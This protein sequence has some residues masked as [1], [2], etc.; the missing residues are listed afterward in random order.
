VAPLTLDRGEALKQ[1][2]RVFWEG[3]PCGAM[4]ASAVEGTPEY[5]AQVEESRYLL[6][7]FIPK[8]ADFEGA[9][10][11]QL[12]EIGVGLGTDLVRFARAGA[13]VTG[14]DLTDHAVELV[15]RRLELEGLD[16][17]VEVADAEALPFP[18]ASFDRVYSWGV[19]H[20]TPDTQRAIDEAI[21]VA[22]PGGEL[23][24]MLYGRHSWVT[25]GMWVRHALLAG[26]PWR[27]LS[28]ILAHHME[29]EGTKGYTPKELRVM[30]RGLAGL[31]VEPISTR[32]DA[33]FAGPLARLFPR[34]GWFV[35]I[36]GTKPA[37]PA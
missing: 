29:S 7:P 22:R 28:D 32:Y 17:E 1:R 16:G 24:V 19:L 12:L 6:E 11:K 30:F 26:R 8:Y 37:A 34:F 4:H 5:F 9:S 36:R 18:D 13:D 21:R 10:G 3:E 33:H 35:V 27:S 15:R 23:C 25:F 31:R 2:V 14:V 20:H